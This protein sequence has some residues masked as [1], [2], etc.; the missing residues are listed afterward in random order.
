[1]KQAVNLEQH[2]LQA[3]AGK[4]RDQFGK[5][6]CGED[7]NEDNSQQSTSHSHSE[8]SPILDTSKEDYGIEQNNNQNED[9]GVC[10]VSNDCD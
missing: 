4:I 3:E 10:D 6:S 9:D 5:S 7:K 2:V 1:M 8:D